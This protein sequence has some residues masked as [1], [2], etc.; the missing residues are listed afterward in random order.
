MVRPIVMSI[1]DPTDHWLDHTSNCW[2]LEEHHCCA[3][4][5]AVCDSFKTDDPS[6]WSGLLSPATR[7]AAIRETGRTASTVTKTQTL[8]NSV[9]T[10]S[11]MRAAV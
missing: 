7:A 10:Y 9:G 3:E 2:P 11:L 4:V 8:S 6:L 1:D 5:F